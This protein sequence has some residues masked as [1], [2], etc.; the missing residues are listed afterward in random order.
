MSIYVACLCVA[1]ISSSQEQIRLAEAENKALLDGYLQE[2][3][4]YKSVQDSMIEMFRMIGY[5]KVRRKIDDRGVRR[6]IGLL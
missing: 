4:L 2:Y 1:H 5:T 3:E 6:L